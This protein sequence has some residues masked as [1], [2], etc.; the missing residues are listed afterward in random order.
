MAKKKKK[1][2]AAPRR[3]QS[4]ANASAARNA[5]PVRTA[6]QPVLPNWLTPAIVAACCLFVIWQME[7]AHLFAS[8]TPTGADLGGQVWG[9]AQLKDAILPALSGWSPQ[10]LGG[11]ALYVLYM[12]VPALVVVLFNIVLPYGVALKLAVAAGALVL[13][14]AAYGLGRLSRLPAP[15]PACL[16]VAVIPF[17]FDDSY[18][19]L[20]GN[21]VSSLIGE[22]DYALGI[23]VLLVAL[24]LM[25]VVM[26][27]GR[28]RA[29][30]V[31]T[32]ALASLMHPLVALMLVICGSLLIAGHALHI[33]VLA[34][35]RIWPILVLVP[36]IGSFWFV[37]FAAYRSQLNPLSYSLAG[38]WTS[39]L[40]PLPAWAEVILIGLAVAGVVRAIRLRHPVTMMLAGT[41]V[42]S[43]FTA[44]AFA[45][46][47]VGGWE[48]QQTQG[49][50]A[51]RM[52][53]FWY[54]SVALLAGIGAGDLFL[55]LARFR[56]PLLTTTGPIL[57]LAL[58]VMSFGII[59]G[60]LP[61]SDVTSV[62]TPG[63]PVEHSKWLFLPEVE[64]SLVS[65]WVNEG[66]SGYEGTPLWP[67]Y[68]RLMETMSTVGRR[69]GCGRAI[70]EDDPSGMYGS[71][72]EFSL[73]P[74]WTNGCIDSM[75]AVPN[76]LSVN[77]TF[78]NLASARLSSSDNE[79]NQPGV[80]YPALDVSR[81]V[82]LLR[83]LGVAYYL[84]FTPKAK[85]EAASDPQ[86]HLVA[87]SGPWK[88]YKVT[89]VS[90]VQG[91]TSRP[92]VVPSASGNALTWLDQAAPWFVSQ[93]G[94]RPA[95]GGPSDWQRVSSSV[96]LAKGSRLPPVRISHLVVSSNSV[97]FHVNRLGVPVEVRMTYFPW[98]QATGA[99]GPWQLA[100][101]NLVVVPTRHE[102]TLTAS[103]RLV[104][105]L[106]VV[107]S[108]FAVFATVGLALWD[109]R[110]RRVRADSVPSEHTEDNGL[111]SSKSGTRV[112]ERV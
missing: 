39:T 31:A 57:G 59:T 5:K 35:R 98:W 63:G 102:V 112:R 22:Y 85:Q 109:R 44:L 111:L 13:P 65:Q 105:H 3:P 53:P 73:L 47:I 87:S 75:K 79:T 58:V 86:L 10:W 33:G 89:G 84:A 20:G 77:Y 93:S 99:E 91:L 55:R 4:A 110:N 25:D 51:A 82:P 8:N 80:S 96:G 52:L 100:P 83:E 107:V 106:A 28:W 7:P 6:P 40:F 92:V 1:R 12:P 30:T 18:F 72:Y 42:I 104:D 68:H 24:G 15:I 23:P 97:S 11:L 17:L 61:L 21:I 45:H 62:N 81:G 78:A 46:G 26:R 38:G 94:A 71:I 64:T 49:W 76:E 19:R 14:V 67:Q 88:V 60:S 16:S 101:D 66:F 48:S 74:Y 103:P 70:A 9:P 41:A 27:T 37:P 56:Y 36:L 50:V 108:V 43:A 2:P 95:S 34:L 32:A 29:L 69:Y 54:L 90:L